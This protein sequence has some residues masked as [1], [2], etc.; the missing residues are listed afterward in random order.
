MVAS[1]L[2]TTSL[3]QVNKTLSFLNLG[4]K[5]YLAARVLLGADLL[6]QGAILGSSAI[7]KYF[8][9]I[10]AFRGS[11]SKGHLKKAHLASVKN[12]DPK[13]YASLN[14][15]FLLFLQKCYELRYFDHIVLGFNLCVESRPTIAE[16]DYTVSEIE[17]RFKVGRRD[18]GLRTMYSLAVDSKDQM[19]YKNNHV[20]K[21]IDKDFFIAQ[22]QGFV[23]EMRLDAKYG[24][25]E[26]MYQ[27]AVKAPHDG[28]F[29]T[30]ALVI[31]LSSS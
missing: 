24:F 1:K 16:L 29:L 17:K 4:F 7:E 20:L 25:I 26:A 6:L 9:A 5:D 3:E 12:F 8:K 18:Q 31:E 10:M 23:Y 13:L 11:V 19:L 2:E 30:E 15:S 27:S 14:E 22:E 21:G 28:N